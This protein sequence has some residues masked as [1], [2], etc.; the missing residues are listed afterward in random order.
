MCPSADPETIYSP[1]SEKAAQLTA[2]LFSL[3]VKVDNAKS[4]ECPIIGL[5]V[6]SLEW[7]AGGLGAGCMGAA[8][9]S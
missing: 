6:I 7:G 1:S 8:I 4:N 9:S 2:T 3:I 5:A